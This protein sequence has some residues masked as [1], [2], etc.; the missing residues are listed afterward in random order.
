MDAGVSLAKSILEKPLKLL[1]EEDISQLTR[2]D[3]RKFLKEKG[4]RRP[5]WNKSQA[6]QQVL[7]LKALFEPG[8]DSGAGFLRKILVSQPE[9]LR[10][11]TSSSTEPTKDSGSGGR[12]RLPEDD[13]NFPYHGKDSPRSEFSGG[14]GQYV[15]EKDSYRTISSRSSSETNSM[16]GQMTIFYCGKVVVYDGILPEKARSVMHFAAS[17]IDM[18]GKDLFGGNPTLCSYPSHPQPATENCGLFAPSIMISK[19]VITDKMVELPQH[20]PEKASPDSAEGQMSRKVS[21][22]R[23]REKRKDRRFSK[24]RKAQGVGSSSLEM[25]LSHQARYG[26]SDI[27]NTAS[28]ENRTKDSNP[29]VDL[30]S[31]EF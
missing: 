20:C 16:V 5:S 25:Y 13:D 27:A 23:Y 28:P 21:L 15:G 17:P 30:N 1:T 22:Q 10:R 19:P 24:G 7:S 12:I 11:V 18:P 14:S 4:M 26:R 29:S 9:N 2:E 31:E 8:D 6:I 3:C